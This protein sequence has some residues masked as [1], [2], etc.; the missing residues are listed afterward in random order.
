VLFRCEWILHFFDFNTEVVVEI[1]DEMG[2]HGEK[3]Q[4]K[5]NKMIE[6]FPKYVVQKF[7]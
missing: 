7:H 4:E 3:F 6:H 1:A 5:S 2:Y